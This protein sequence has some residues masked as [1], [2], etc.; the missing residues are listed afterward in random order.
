SPGAR[1]R[2]PEPVQSSHSGDGPG[3]EPTPRRTP[4]ETLGGYAGAV[5]LVGL[6][7]LVASSA[8]SALQGGNVVMPFL[9][10]VL[11]AGAG[12]GL[13][14]ALVAALLA[15]VTYNF[16]YLEPRL[17]FRIAHPADLLTFSVFFAVALATGWLAGRPRYHALRA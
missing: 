9:L 12:F 7:N 1:H 11:A 10:S 8:G 6:A 4:G 14:P 5:V 16:F 2:G 17:T 15:G 13:G 3:R